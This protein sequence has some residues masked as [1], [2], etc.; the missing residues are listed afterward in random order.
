MHVQHT[1][2]MR[3]YVKFIKKRLRAVYKGT[4]VYD[5]DADAL[6]LALA[7]KAEVYNGRL[8]MVAFALLIVRPPLLTCAHACQGKG[9]AAKSVDPDGACLFI[10]C[11]VHAG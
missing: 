9:L 8:A 6:H 2:C 3:V 1:V 11:F 7:Q 4:S 10:S 5:R